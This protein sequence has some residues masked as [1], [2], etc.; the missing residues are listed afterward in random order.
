MPPTDHELVR[1]F[2]DGDA[3]C[4]GRIDTWILEVLRHARLQP[5]GDVDDL[6]QQVRRRLLEA[7]RGGSFQGTATLRTYVWRAA[8]HAAIDHRRMRRTRPS[9]LT[10]DDVAEPRDPC[11]S[12][13]GALLQQERREIFT[14]VLSRLGDACRDLFQLIIFEELSYEA[15][16]LRLQT[17][18]GAIKVRALRCREKAVVEYKAVTSSRGARQLSQIEVN[19]L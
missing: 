8:Q 16:A 11:A 9:P 1:G 17:T 4:V 2:L 10:I 3:V 12:P 7:F 13:E 6:A 19:E 18:E 15:I 14:L 5:A